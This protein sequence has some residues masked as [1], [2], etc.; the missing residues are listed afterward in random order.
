[1]LKGINKGLHFKLGR[2]DDIEQ[3]MPLVMV[4]VAA[5]V[6]AVVAEQTMAGQR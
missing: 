2:A 4:S 1:M 6:S 5:P 3:S